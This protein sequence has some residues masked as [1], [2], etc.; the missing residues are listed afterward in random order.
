MGA[1]EA[2]LVASRRTAYTNWSWEPV[3]QKRNPMPGNPLV[4]VLVKPLRQPFPD[5]L[6]SGR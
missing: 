4:Y 1:M 3:G 2:R 6:M 5:V